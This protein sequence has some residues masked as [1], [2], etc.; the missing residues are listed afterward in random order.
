[1]GQWKLSITFVSGIGFWIYKTKM[2]ITILLPGISIYIGLTKE[3]KGFNFFGS[4]E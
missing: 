2:D 1:M 4:G 3:A